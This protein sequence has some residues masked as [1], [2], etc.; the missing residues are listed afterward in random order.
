MGTQ[1]RKPDMSWAAS[2]AAEGNDRYPTCLLQYRQQES[3]RLNELLGPEES[4]LSVCLCI[5]C[6]T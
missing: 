5:Q 4:G 6:V 3:P 2:K 1:P